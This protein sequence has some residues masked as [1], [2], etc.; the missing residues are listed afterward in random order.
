LYDNLKSLIYVVF[1]DP[2][3]AMNDVMTSSYTKAYV[4]LMEIGKCTKE[5]TCNTYIVKSNIGSKES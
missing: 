3:K 5:H 4:E 2:H 1:V